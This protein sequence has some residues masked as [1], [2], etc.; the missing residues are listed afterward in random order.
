MQ[1]IKPAMPY[2]ISLIIGLLIAIT[3]K[4]IYHPLV[5]HGSSMES[6]YQDGDIVQCSTDF[7]VESLSRGDVIAYLNDGKLVVKRI[8][9]L[10]GEEVEVKDRYIYVDGVRISEK[11][12]GDAGILEIKNIQLGEDEYF[13][14]GDN[15][16]VSRDSRHTGPVRFKNIKYRLEGLLF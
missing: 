1:K 2:V 5:I 7:T 10:P 14:L 8:V 13:C 3:I 12:V 6:A 15:H 11:L 4:C 9:A 16:E